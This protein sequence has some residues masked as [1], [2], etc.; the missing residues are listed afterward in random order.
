MKPI[1][2]LT[3]ILLLSAACCGL[4]VA[5]TTT[6][7]YSYQGP[8]LPILYNSADAGTVMNLNVP[9][10]ISISNVTVNVNIDYPTVGDLNVF[11]FGP[12]GT[13]TILVERNCGSQSTLVNITFSDAGGSMYSQFC[14]AQSS[15]PSYR[16]NQPLANYNGKV[17]AGN[18]SLF[19]ENN[20]SNTSFGTVDGFSVTITGQ[21]L[22]PAT[23]SGIGNAVG[24][25]SIGAVSPG[26]LVAIQGT[27]IGPTPGVIS[28][29]NTLPTTLGGVQ[30]MANGVQPIPLYYVSANLIAG[31]IPYQT[32]IP[33]PMNPSGITGQVTL[34]V[35]YN[36]VTSNG[37]VVNVTTSTPAVFTTI[38]GTNN[39][40]GIKALNSDG[41]LNTTSNRAA[42]GSYVTLYASGLGPVTPSG[43]QAG[44]TAPTGTLYTV[45]GPTFVAI[46][47]ESATVLF[48]GLA[49]GT[50][51]VYQVNVQIP[52]NVPSGQQPILVSNTTGASQ[53]GVSIWI[54]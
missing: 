50:I 11:V 17:S 47:G 29:A 35:V 19:V 8:S 26:Q 52:S 10:A 42:A 30:V 37:F 31:V 1:K 21:S 18:W 25:G 53:S 23:I 2:V 28:T 16:G 3:S 34:T 14:P 54:K 6:A 9:A 49:P 51:S 13:R 27:N 12:D 39:I 43:F 48:S 4:A 24:G 36:G 20:G 45:V 32:G 46:G 22:T 38:S 40:V 5:Q 44:A 33:L 15:P 7:T 41:T